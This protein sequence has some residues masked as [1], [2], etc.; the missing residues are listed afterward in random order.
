[1]PSAPDIS[2]LRFEI[3]QIAAPCAL[4]NAN[5][6]LAMPTTQLL[7]SSSLY[8]FEAS[9]NKSANQSKLCT[10]ISSALCGASA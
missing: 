3:Q 8:A 2:A 6:A 1:M 7:S 5:I 9:H 10:C 4:S